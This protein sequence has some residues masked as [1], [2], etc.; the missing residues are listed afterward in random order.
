MIIDKVIILG[1]GALATGAFSTVPLGIWEFST[2]DT[3]PKAKKLSEVNRNIKRILQEWKSPESKKERDEVTKNHKELL[4]VMIC[5]S[6]QEPNKWNEG[7][8]KLKQILGEHSYNS[9]KKYYDVEKCKQV[10]TQS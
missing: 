4:S 10:N 3:K 5:I 8:Q 2:K 7:E 6:N 9:W 1:K